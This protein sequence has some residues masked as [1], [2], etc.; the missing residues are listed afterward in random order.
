MGHA[1]KTY[2]V[3]VDNVPSILILDATWR[4]IVSLTFRTLHPNTK[5]T[6]GTSNMGR[7]V[8][9]KEGIDVLV[10]L[11]VLLFQG[12]DPGLSSS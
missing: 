12:I 3:R 8:Y 2:S 6:A 7:W 1:P 5:N 9:P 4:L 10:N 11:N